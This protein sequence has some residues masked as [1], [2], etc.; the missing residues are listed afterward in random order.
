MFW[1]YRPEG[2]LLSG[3]ANGDSASR[4]EVAE[5]QRLRPAALPDRRRCCLR[6]D[7]PVKL[8]PATNSHAYCIRNCWRYLSISRNRL[9]FH[10]QTN[11]R[12]KVIFHYNENANLAAVVDQGNRQ[13]N[14][15]GS[16]A[17]QLV[18]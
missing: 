3:D 1:Y 2:A 4:P 9:V 7:L 10:R 5:E 12:P 13:G 18:S 6:L 17:I 14:R 8:F 15:V 11:K 16:I